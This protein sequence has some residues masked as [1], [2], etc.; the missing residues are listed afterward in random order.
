MSAI[1][2]LSRFYFCVNTFL[3]Y[4]SQKKAPI[5]YTHI[6]SNRR[7]IKFPSYNIRTTWIWWK[8]RPL[9]CSR[10]PHINFVCKFSLLSFKLLLTPWH[11]KREIDYFSYFN[12]AHYLHY[13]STHTALYKEVNFKLEVRVL[14]EVS[15]YLEMLKSLERKGCDRNLSPG[16]SV[17]V[18]WWGV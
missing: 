17:F 7:F 6:S 11:F 5:R 10:K 3:L 14:Q 4:V 8:S 18:I 13:T 15:S 12:Y 9:Y 1:I 16:H 2:I